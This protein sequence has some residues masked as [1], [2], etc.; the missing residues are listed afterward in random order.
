MF[1]LISYPATKRHVFYNAVTQTQEW[2]KEVPIG[3][4]FEFNGLSLK[5][6]FEI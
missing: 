4:E 5:K 1:H 6:V 3:G 2:Y